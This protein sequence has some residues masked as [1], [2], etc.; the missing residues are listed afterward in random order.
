LR[1]VHNLFSLIFS[2]VTSNNIRYVV[3]GE[4]NAATVSPLSRTGR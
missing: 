4:F 2:D 1:E 3:V